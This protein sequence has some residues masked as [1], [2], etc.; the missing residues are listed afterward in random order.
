SKV[1]PK[2]LKSVTLLVSPQDAAKL[3]LGQSKGKL[4]LSLRNYGDSAQAAI[5]PVHVTQLLGGDLSREPAKLI[6]TPAAPPPPLQIR[7][8]PG[9]QEGAVLV[10][11]GQIAP[12]R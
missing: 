12:T 11:P 10:Q 2:E 9:S 3:T 4:H 7:T 8:V 5:R 1:D 6:V